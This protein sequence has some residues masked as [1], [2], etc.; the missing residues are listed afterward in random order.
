LIP[1][2]ITTGIAAGVI[3]I[4]TIAAGIAIADTT[5]TGAQQGNQN[6]GYWSHPG[7]PSPCRDLWSILRSFPIY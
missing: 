5:G 4:M 6:K 3:R 7:K 1:S 2:G